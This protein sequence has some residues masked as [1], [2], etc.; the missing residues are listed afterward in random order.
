MSSDPAGSFSTTA[1]F[2]SPFGI[3]WPAMEYVV[4][5]AQRTTL[6]WDVMR[7]RGNQYREH[8]AEKA[9]HVLNYEPQLVIDGR[10]LK[11][12]VNYVLVRSRH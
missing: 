1:A 10:T 12:P 8:I 4:D 2:T 7:Q 11:R 5:A 6:F 9:P 3:L